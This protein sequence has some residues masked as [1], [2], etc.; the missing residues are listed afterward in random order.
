MNPRGV[1]RLLVPVALV[2]MA[3]TCG[4]PASEDGAGA[5][6]TAPAETVDPDV[7]AN[8]RDEG[9]HRS[10]VMEFAHVLTDLYGPRYANSPSYDGASRWARDTLEGF[11]LKA[12]LEP[13]GEFGYA[14]ENRFTSVHITAPQYQPVIGYAQPGT[15]S[16]NGSVAGPVAAVDLTT[17]R[18]RDDLNALGERIGT[19]ILL[20]S[21]ERELVPNFLPQA[22]RLSDEELS[23]MARLEID[24]RNNP[25]QAADDDEAE[26]EL[27]RHDIERFLEQQGVD[28]LVEV[29]SANVGPMDKGIVH[30]SGD[31][32]LP[33]DEPL[34]MPR[35]VVAAEHYNRMMRL[36][37][38][39]TPVSMEVEV[40]NVLS[41]DDP[42]DYN[43]IAELP[44]GDLA[45]EVVM[46][47]GHLD[48][49]PAGTG[50]T[51]NAA[52]SAIVIEAMRLLRA[53]D[54]RPRRTIRAALWG[55]E[56][57][58][59]LGSRGYVREHFGGPPADGIPN[60]AAN[61]SAGERQAGGDP[62]APDKPAAHA[63]LSVYFNVD[64]YGRFRGMY[65]QGNDAS[66]PIFEAWMAPFHDVGM[67]WIVPGNTCCTDHMAFLEAGLQGFQFIQ[68]DLEFFNA[69]F[70]TNM[71]VYD[72][73][74]ADDLQ[75]AS[76]ILASFAYHAA[77]REGPFPRADGLNNGRRWHK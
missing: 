41:A 10:R 35:V 46:I 30:V 6:S 66:R 33:L 56:E 23:G 54:A 55:A 14:W 24:P 17:I 16:T 31:G 9:F 2:A 26:P 57:T 20:V 69:T 73:L 45:H 48:A 71:D 1:N 36:L 70:H 61:G 67:S 59:L 27:T 60:G 47:G 75:Q 7:V 50:A 4:G 19:S 42:L 8:L 28:V 53:I 38:A 40:R 5:S 74:I 49:E 13:W 52:G 64:W 62:K 44:G 25:V 76:V 21:P 39:G 34:P 37:A 63:N 68:D 58:G 32:P 18:T 77:M 43:V 65:L 72:R 51:D 3:A 11:G 22:V 15:R 12:A 29:G